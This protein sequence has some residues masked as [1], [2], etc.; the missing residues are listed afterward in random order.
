VSRELGAEWLPESARDEWSRFVSRS[1]TGSAYSLPAYL[2][3]L[4]SAGGGR[5][6]VLAVRKGDELVGGLTVYERDTPLGTTVRPRL[7]LYYNGLVLREESTAYPSER[8]SRS[9]RVAA[10]LAA[11]LEREGY[12]RVELRT[13][14]PFADARPF[15]SR[16]WTAWPSYSYVVRLDDLEAQWS[17]TEQNLRRLV[18]RC[19][20]SGFDLAVDGDF[21]PF[22]ALHAATHR[23]KGAPLYLQAAAFRRFYEELQGQGLCRLFHAIA[24]GGA[25]A[26]SQLVL[27]G[28]PVTHTVTAGTH[29]DF[30]SSGA[31][32]FLRWK[33]FEHLAADG[34][35][36]NDLTDAALNPVTHFKSQ[37][38]GDL[39]TAVVV[40]TATLRD[41]AAEV[42]WATARRSRARL[43]RR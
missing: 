43:R 18:R 4:A 33:V 5:S 12:R 15:Q 13:R 24:P 31:A 17:R 25:V 11:A 16:G 40:S 1:P 20:R 23:E 22:Y 21:E 19:E 10:A 6:R 41:R 30:A 28:H 7:L 29:A 9:L 35:R 36:G 8:A 34:Y 32:A 26:A 39:E 2:G 14:A 38:G 37:L 27:L 42:A 3:A